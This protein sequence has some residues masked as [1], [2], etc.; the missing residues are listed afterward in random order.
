MVGVMFFVLFAI[1]I[2]LN[3]INLGYGVSLTVLVLSLVLVIVI[4]TY[5]SKRHPFFKE[6]DKYRVFFPKIQ[7]I[8]SVLLIEFSM[9]Y[10]SSFFLCFFWKYS[11]YIRLHKLCICSI[12]GM[13]SIYCC[14]NEKNSRCSVLSHNYYTYMFIH[15]DDSS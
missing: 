10:Y 9:V 2:V 4:N 1:L 7:S 14:E 12:N 5:I 15:S 13:F 6:T 8:V 3:P 11:Y